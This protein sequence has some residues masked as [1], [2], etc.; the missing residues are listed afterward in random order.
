MIAKV[1][2]CCGQGI[3]EPLPLGVKFI[4]VG[5]RLVELVHKAGPA[6]IAT[7]ALFER[8]YGHKVDGGPEQGLKVIQVHIAHINKKLQTVGKRIGG[9]RAGG[10]R[11]NF[12][13]YR[14]E[15]IKPGGDKHVAL[16]KT[17]LRA[18]S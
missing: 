8:L 2:P 13:R 11:G 4:G 16:D 7:D 12:N 17:G 5:K 14:L 3:P 6:G 9:E 10:A 18:G 1:C 15:D